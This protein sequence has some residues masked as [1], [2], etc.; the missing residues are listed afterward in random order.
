MPLA[1]TCIKYVPGL[2]QTQ[3]DLQLPFCKTCLD[4]GR[5]CGGYAFYPGFLIRTRQGL[6]KRGLPEEVNRRQNTVLQP[7]SSMVSFAKTTEI[8]RRR[9]PDDRKPVIAS[10]SLQ[11]GNAAA[12]ESQ[13]LSTFWEHHIPQQSV[14]AGCQCLWLQE[15]LGLPDPSPALRLALKAVAMTRL[16]WLYR[17]N[18]LVLHGRVLYGQALQD[19]QK[20]LY[21]E[22]SMWRDETLATGNILAL[23]E[24]DKSPTL[25]LAL[26]I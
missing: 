7:V 16:G 25:R 13:L 2:H 15:A 24:V 1:I 22:R 23:Y 3:C 4:G 10:M 6:A 21:D 9:L 19:T 12:F 17:D 11:P 5:I 14:Q 8:Q 18:T 20:A 26:G